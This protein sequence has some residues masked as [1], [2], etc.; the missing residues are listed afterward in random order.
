M[1]KVLKSKEILR[2]TKENMYKTCKKPV[3]PVVTY[4]EVNY[5]S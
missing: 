1:R 4:M 2:K 3:K 5:G